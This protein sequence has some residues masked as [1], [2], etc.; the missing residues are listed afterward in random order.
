[1]KNYAA[2]NS[3]ESECGKIQI[4]WD[5]HRQNFNSICQKNPSS[6]TNH[7][8]EKLFAS[9]TRLLKIHTSMKMLKL[10]EKV[11]TI[12]IRPFKSK[13]ERERHLWLERLFGDSLTVF[14]ECDSIF[15]LT[16]FKNCFWNRIPFSLI[17]NTIAH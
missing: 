11:A 8:L 12:N 16:T 10:H 15:V 17:L 14:W 6:S 1:M 13:R 2:R 9:K 5:S 3:G 7:E 4:C